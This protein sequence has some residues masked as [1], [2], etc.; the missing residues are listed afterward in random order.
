M[1]F[2]T[3]IGSAFGLLFLLIWVYTLGLTFYLKA[4]AYVNGRPAMRTEYLRLLLEGFTEGTP[5]LYSSDKRVYQDAGLDYTRALTG[6][7]VAG[8]IS[9]GFMIVLCTLLFWP[10]TLTI[11]ILRG[12]RRYNT[13]EEFHG[14]FEREIKPAKTQLPLPKPRPK[15]RPQKVIKGLD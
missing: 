13:D 8:I 7:N 1:N 14:L 12:L 4:E 3:Y 2:Y 10:V 5:K 11:L 9:L 6:E 15:P